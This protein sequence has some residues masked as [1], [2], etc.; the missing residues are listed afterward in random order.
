M[1]AS[2]LS[3]AGNAFCVIDTRHG[4]APAD[5]EALARAICAAVD[6]PL[7]VAARGG[8]LPEL[9]G[10]A[11]D[12]LLLVGAPRAMA[13]CS[14]VVHNA[15][16]TRPKA[17]GNGLRCVGRFAREHGLA[18]SELVR[19]ETD[20]GVRNV[21]VPDCGEGPQPAREVSVTASMGRP[22]I[23]AQ[24]ETLVLGDAEYAATLID[25]GN[26]HCVLFVD[27]PA[28]ADVAHLGAALERHPRFPE[29][30][31]VEFAA[32]VGET[33]ALRVWERGVGETAACGT[34]ACA[35]AV[36]A[37][38]ERGAV[39]PLAVSLPGGKLRV[40]WD[41]HGE[42]QLEGPVRLHAE[43]ALEFDASTGELR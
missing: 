11:L 40:H 13:D 3:A 6:H 28:A 36:A 9:D 38:L 42:V 26:P 23:I 10:R 37:A 43:G 16:G 14:M 18:P 32:L 33:L 34:G 1:K 39:M 41:G 7:I 21:Q 12:G 2:I 4:S 17:C 24:A 25:M 5:P 15:D 8:G 27:D 19:V 30:T 29:R 20:A 35:A 31:N 22:K